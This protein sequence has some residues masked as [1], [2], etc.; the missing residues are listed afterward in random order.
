VFQSRMPSRTRKQCINMKTI[1]NK[2]FA[3]KKVLLRVDFDIPLTTND[4]CL[5]EP[6]RK[7]QTII[8]DDL[9]IRAS[10]PTIEYLLK[11]GAAKIILLAHLGRPKGK[12]VPAYTLWP[13]AN[14]LSE[15]LKLKAKFS[16]PKD[17]YQISEKIVLLENTRFNP[18]EEKNDPKYAKKLA[19]LGDS[20]HGEA[21]I[22]VNDAFATCHR[23]HA[24]TEGI[25][26]FLPSYAGLQLEKE[27]NELSKL[28]NPACPF[29]CILGGA[30]V[31]E[32]IKV[33]ENLAQKTD[34]FLLSGVMANTFLKALGKDVKDSAVADDVLDKAKKL[35]L[36]LKGKI[37]LPEDLIF[38]NF[39]GKQMLLDNSPKDIEK[40][41][42]IIMEAKTIFWNGNIGKSEIKP[43]DKG[44]R[45][46][47]KI[48]ARATKKGVITVVAG[49]DTTGFVDKIGL[50]NKMSYIS[51]AGGAAL[52]FLAGKKLPGIKTLL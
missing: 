33:I 43:F 7:R 29:V 3:G 18:G 27:V 40:F 32:K 15:L 37:I 38:G 21:G 46:I 49:G 35:Y 48:L 30:K 13:I 52:E 47:A 6:R 44:T 8:S 34:Q 24:S 31:S 5:A 9:R 50:A 16:S 36:E 12:F 1:M 41:G 23:A 17:E 2:N 22:F 39:E 51:M 25:T 10:L 45:A 14:R 19:R 42:N 26:H 11:S 28:L 4:T 20:P